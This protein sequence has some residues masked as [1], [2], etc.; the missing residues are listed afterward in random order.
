MLGISHLKN[1]FL[2]ISKCIFISL[3]CSLIHAIYMIVI[4][5]EIM[6][7]NRV[8]PVIL[9]PELKTTWEN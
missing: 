3:V 5:T 6:K 2:I 9:A 8:S 7:A 1:L 4:K